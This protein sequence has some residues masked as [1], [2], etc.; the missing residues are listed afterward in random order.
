MGIELNT[1]TIYYSYIEYS[2]ASYGLNDCESYERT[3]HASLALDNYWGRL[4]IIVGSKEKCVL[5]AKFLPLAISYSCSIPIFTWWQYARSDAF[6]TF[7]Y[8]PIN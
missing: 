4:Q 7:N 6:N 3:K 2:E 1:Y 8:V 5:S